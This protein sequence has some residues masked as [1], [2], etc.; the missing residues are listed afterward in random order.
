MIILRRFLGF[1]RMASDAQNRPQSKLPLEIWLKVF[2]YA[3]HIPG[4]YTCD[5]A[6]TLLAFAADQ[7]GIALHSRHREATNTMLSASLVCKAWTPI[8]TEYLFRYLLVKSGDHVVK[9]ATTLD[10]LANSSLRSPSPCRFT[11]RLELFLEG[12]HQWKTTHTAALT[13]ILSRCVNIRVFSTAFMS[14]DA[15]YNSQQFVNAMQAVGLRSNIQRLELKGNA[16]LFWVVLPALAPHLEC[17]VL[18]PLYARGTRSEL[19]FPNLRTF[20][21]SDRWAIPLDD[22]SSALPGLPFRMPALRALHLSPNSST[23][24][25]F[26]RTVAGQLEYLSAGGNTSSALELCSSLNSLTEW[27]LPVALFVSIDRANFPPTL[28]VVNLDGG[29]AG[30]PLG[31]LA[32]WVANQRPPA[33]TTIRFLL[34]FRRHSCEITQGTIRVVK[35]FVGACMKWDIRI[36]LAKGVDQHTSRS[37]VPATVELLAAALVGH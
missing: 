28:R 11:L 5:D 21:L 37:Y 29:L 20:I 1:Q 34:P 19:T 16:A 14:V 36:E 30:F 25:D 32:V 23:H 26:F 13:S 9:I 4:A 10:S 8:V 6:P 17:L 24:S 33:L 12:V 35:L 2:E 7:H 22:D 27:T 31:N 15:P 18:V 3:T